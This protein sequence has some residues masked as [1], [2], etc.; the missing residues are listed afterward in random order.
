MLLL[1]LFENDLTL[2]LKLLGIFSD[3]DLMVAG[4]VGRGNLISDLD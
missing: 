1:F 2:A 4:S 3:S